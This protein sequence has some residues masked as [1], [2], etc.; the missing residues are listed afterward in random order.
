[1]A[2]GPYAVSKI[3]ACHTVGSHIPGQCRESV[4]PSE[5]VRVLPEHSDRSGNSELGLR[6]RDRRVGQQDGA[7][8]GE[9]QLLDAT[10]KTYFP[11]Q[12]VLKIKLRMSSVVVAPV[13]ASR[14]RRPL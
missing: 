3:L 8:A 13:I 4:D 1:M 14:A 9:I 11:M 6:R 10:G 2:G 7:T 12:N 5:M